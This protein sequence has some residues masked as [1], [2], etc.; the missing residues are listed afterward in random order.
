MGG[1]PVSG[2]SFSR[3]ATITN[4]FNM[5]VRLHK[6]EARR[7]IVD[8]FSNPFS[9]L[10]TILVIAIALAFPAALLVVLD[11]SQSVFQRWHGVSRISLYLKM[12]TS[13]ERLLSL[14]KEVKQRE[15]VLQVEVITQ[16]QALTEF[17]LRSGFAD[18]LKQL[19][20]NPL[21][22]V[23]VVQPKKEHRS[24]EMSA[25]MLT[26][27]ENFPD[28]D[29]AKLDLDWL[30]KLHALIFLAKK[31]VT[32]LALVLATAV[33]LIVGNTIRLSVQNRRDEIEIIKLIGATDGFIR[34]PFLYTGLWYG[35]LAGIIS[36]II[37]K[38]SFLWL[39]APIAHLASLYQSHFQ[40]DGLD[41]LQSILLVLI[42]CLLGLLGSW[43]SVGP[44][45]RQIEPM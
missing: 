14:A 38:F 5:L 4:R 21:P 29:I 22:P 35:L 45:I 27:L 40:L 18:A 30:R 32:G 19:D 44:H 42:S 28:V 41:G 37:L 10:M 1:E 26:E 9:N 25:L 36:W 6:A 8:I 11:D 15:D 7:A 12:D 39:Q 16:E 31:I 24:P 20:S 13:E 2:A 23:L 34:R 17:K 33:L 3:G 43:L